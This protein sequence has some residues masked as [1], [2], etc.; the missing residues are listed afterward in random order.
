MVSFDIFN[1]Y[2]YALRI[3]SLLHS[4]NIE[5]N[6]FFGNLKTYFQIDLTLINDSQ[7]SKLISI[8]QTA[9]VENVVFI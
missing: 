9:D 5:P 1:N 2:R 8:I 6:V 4:C 7:K 3:I